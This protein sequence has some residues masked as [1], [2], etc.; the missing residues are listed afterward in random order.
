MRAHE[1][2]GEPFVDPGVA[3]VAIAVL[4]GAR[5]LDDVA[6]ECGVSRMT[7]YERLRRAARQGLVDWEPGLYG[8]LRSTLRVV[9]LRKDPG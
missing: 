7:A 5:Y 6:A 8:T 9:A 2:S 3:A 1:V 4:R